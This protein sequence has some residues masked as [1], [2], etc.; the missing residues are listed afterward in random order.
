MQIKPSE[1]TKMTF[2]LQELRSFSGRDFGVNSIYPQVRVSIEMRNSTA[3]S[4]LSSKLTEKSGISQQFTLPRPNCPA[5]QVR[6]VSPKL[7]QHLNSACSRKHSAAPMQKCDRRACVRSPTR[8][9]RPNGS[10]IEQYDRC[11]HPVAHLRWL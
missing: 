10:G 5:Q 1:N 3:F 7:R 9:V 11:P 6:P 4:P 8:R 2:Y